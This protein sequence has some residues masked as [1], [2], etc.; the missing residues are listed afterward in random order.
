MNT[1]EKLKMRFYFFLI[2]TFSIIS[3]IL[4]LVAGMGYE[5][6]ASETNIIKSGNIEEKKVIKRKIRPAYKTQKSVTVKQLPQKLEEEYIEAPRY[7]LKVSEPIPLKRVYNPA[8]LCAI[9]VSLTKEDIHYY[10]EDLKYGETIDEIDCAAQVLG[11]R[12]VRRFINDP[13]IDNVY[14]A[15]INA[16][17]EYDDEILLKKIVESLGKLGKDEAGSILVSY[18]SY[19]EYNSVKSAC[20]RALGN[21]KYS[22][23]VHHLIRILQSNSYR[24]LRIQSASALGQIRDKAAVYPLISALND[25]DRS[26]R[27]VAIGALGNIGSQEAKYQLMHILNY[28]TDLELREDAA[29]ALRKIENYRE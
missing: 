18:L 6:L 28:D 29:Q 13:I 4:I 12:S 7:K 3:T 22:G 21:L 25:K 1:E 24:N 8:S 20:I 15:L 10:V 16:F 9:P 23:A 5:G 2:K 17:R 14:N 11:S 27:K 19:G 26:L